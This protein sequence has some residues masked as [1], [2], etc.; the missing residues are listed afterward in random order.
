MSS[1]R[2]RSREEES[3]QYSGQFIGL[4]RVTEAG[5]ISRLETWASFKNHA[6]NPQ[7]DQ[8][9]RVQ[10]LLILQSPEVDQLN[11]PASS[12]SGRVL[13][14]SVSRSTVFIPGSHLAPQLFQSYYRV[15]IDASKEDLNGCP[16]FMVKLKLNDFN[17]RLG[18]LRH[19]LGLCVSATGSLT[20]NVDVL[21]LIRQWEA[22]FRSYP[23]VN[24]DLIRNRIQLSYEY[25]LGQFES[26]DLML[27]MPG[28]IHSVIGAT[29]QQTVR[30]KVSSELCQETTRKL[31]IS[32]GSFKQAAR[33]FE[34][35]LLARNKDRMT[36]NVPLAEMKE[37]DRK[38]LPAQTVPQLQQLGVVVVRGAISKQYAQAL[39][40][41]TAVYVQQLLQLP[42]SLDL[43]KPADAAMLHNKRL[44]EE[45]GIS[46]ASIRRQPENSRSTI[47]AK[48]HGISG[49]GIGSVPLQQVFGYKGASAAGGLQQL[50]TELYTNLFPGSNGK[51]EIH[52]I[53]IHLQTPV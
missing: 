40:Q 51:H 45:N 27:F 47:F 41:H 3:V 26:G 24:E 2:R 7:P 9:N 33:D 20:L 46:N 39:L 4:L 38:S 10:N 19:F 36:C 42:S 5:S 37:E 28:L 12:E 34:L 49:I 32:T 21:N 25:L 6:D 13:K 18:W 43:L 15:F 48:D 53:S 52:D 29:D 1:K 44:R 11:T 50:F 8:L 22:L 17:T 31:D 30:I 35:Q 16:A 14:T 23:G